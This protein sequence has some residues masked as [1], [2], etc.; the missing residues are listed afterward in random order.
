MTADLHDLFVTLA[1][2]T[3]NV[4]D[5]VQTRPRPSPPTIPPPT[6]TP[7]DLHVQGRSRRRVKHHKRRQV[8]SSDDSDSDHDPD[9]NNDNKEVNDD[10]AIAD[11]T[12]KTEIS[13]IEHSLASRVRTL[14][15]DLD[16][17]VKSIQEGL[18]DLSMVQ[19]AEDEDVEIW[20]MLSFALQDW[21]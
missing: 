20:Q 2:E 8:V 10:E 6:S 5:E 17:K 19:G 14:S 18:E 9:N 3:S 16:D 15:K 21:K 12:L 1:L 7:K 13:F 4:P 11:Q